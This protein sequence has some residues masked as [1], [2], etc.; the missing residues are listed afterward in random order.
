M[1]EIYNGNILGSKFLLVKNT[2][3]NL[4]VNLDG[5][6]CFINF[7]DLINKIRI[8]DLSDTNKIFSKDAKKNNSLIIKDKIL[9]VKNIEEILNLKTTHPEVF[10]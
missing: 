5:I 9:E 3:N 7:D 2:D 6:S 10:I 8:S 4:F 1:I